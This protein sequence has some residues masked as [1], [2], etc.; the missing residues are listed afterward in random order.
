[1]SKHSIYLKTINEIKNDN[2]SFNEIE[3]K[4]NFNHMLFQLFNSYFVLHN[5]I[6]IFYIL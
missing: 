5:N 2:V 4:Y 6:E 3:R 1:M